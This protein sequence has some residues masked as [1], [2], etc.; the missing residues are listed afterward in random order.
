MSAADPFPRRVA[1][2]IARAGVVVTLSP[3]KPWRIDGTGVHAPVGWYATAEL[4]GDKLDRIE[5]GECSSPDA[6]SALCG[7]LRLRART[8]GYRA[9]AAHDPKGERYLNAACRENVPKALDASAAKLRTLAD[10]IERA[11]P[12]E[13]P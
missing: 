4:V 13:S 10:A 8:E 1:A 2:L 6:R 12:K 3:D 11:W 9:A 5:R 7:A